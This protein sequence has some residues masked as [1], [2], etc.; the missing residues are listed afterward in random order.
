MADTPLV[1]T[2]YHLA[3]GTL[4]RVGEAVQPMAHMRNKNGMVDWSPLVLQG[5]RAAIP[6]RRRPAIPI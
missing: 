1:V 2:P 4:L 6:E 5:C 3:S